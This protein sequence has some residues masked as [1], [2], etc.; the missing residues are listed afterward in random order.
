[1]RYFLDTEFLETGST[2]ELISIGIVAE[3]GREFYAENSEFNWY[4]AT[5]WLNENV[6]PHLWGSAIS[7]DMRTMWSSFDIAG[8]FLMRSSFEKLIWEFC[9]PSVY[10][11]PE[12]WGYYADY[13]WVVF[14][15]L[16][17]RMIDLP[18]S[19]PKYC[20]D[21]KQW[22]DDLGL[23]IPPPPGIEHHALIDARWN[24]E[25]YDFLKAND[26]RNHPK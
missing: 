25:A 6:K 5:D 14:C 19:F 1:M 15:W 16:F 20:R 2:I 23:K 18:V 3:D 12:F 4:N 13:D 24:K 9:K 22:A 26:K 7:P 11:K 8:G 21:L 17:G 10:G